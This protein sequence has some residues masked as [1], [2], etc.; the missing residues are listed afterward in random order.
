VFSA[1]NKSVEPIKI[2]AAQRINGPYRQIRRRG[3]GKL[4]RVDPDVETLSLETVI[5]T[6]QPFRT[7]VRQSTL[8]HVPAKIDASRILFRREA[9]GFG[10]LINLIVAGSSCAWFTGETPV[11]LFHYSY[12]NAS[13]GSSAAALRAG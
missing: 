6:L 4:I 1:D 11:P 7:P 13:I 10:W 9:A 12:R 2:S 5:L 3:A 8:F